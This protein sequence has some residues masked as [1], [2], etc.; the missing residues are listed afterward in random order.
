MTSTIPAVTGSVQKKTTRSGRTYLYLV[1]N[2]SDELGRFVQKWEGTGLR[3]EGNMKKAKTLL[4]KR[5]D[6]INAERRR[7]ALSYNGSEE[8]HEDMMLSTWLQFFCDH[9]MNGIRDVTREGYEYRFKSIL[10][11]FGHRKNDRMLSELTT[12]DINDFCMFMLSKGKINQ[13]TGEPTGYSVRTVRS[14]KALIV[15]AL[16]DAVM[17]GLM[18]VNVAIPVRIGSNGNEAHARKMKF[19]T[20]DELNEFLQWLDDEGDPMT[21]MIKVI[22][23]LGLRKSEALGLTWGPEGVD[24]IA[25]RIRITRTVTRCKTV[26]DEIDTKNQTSARSFVM[27]DELY[28]LFSRMW[29]KRQEDMAFYGNTYHQNDRVFCWEDGL[30]FA[31]DWTVKHFKKIMTKY[32]R[33]D[34][35]LHNLR[36]SAATFLFEMGWSE[37]EIAD[38]LGHADPSTTKKWYAV[39]SKAHND[40]KARRLEGVLKI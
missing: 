19:M 1:I 33:P 15:K 39:I 7:E 8:L 20:I 26:H 9:R 31:P 13:K 30:E 22:T 35:T 34:F 17:E 18:K 32:G 23:Y 6:E 2:D 16:N 24:M 29:A 37:W 28:G 5:L 27:N 3:A 11:Y 38:W 4:Q 36:H 10:E 40:E 12:R 21:D 25:R 14:L